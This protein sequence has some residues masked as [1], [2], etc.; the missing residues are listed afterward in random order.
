M[1]PSN[2]KLSIKMRNTIHKSERTRSLIEK[3]GCKIIFLPPYSPDLNPIE[4]LWANI[5]AR[6]R[7]VAKYIDDFHEAINYAFQYQ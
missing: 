4:N 1:N 6:V 5:K 2:D 7:K 3:A